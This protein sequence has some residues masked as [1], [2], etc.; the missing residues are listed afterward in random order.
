[1]ARAEKVPRAV[2]RR[3]RSLERDVPRSSALRGHVR[4]PSSRPSNRPMSR[5][6][7]PRPSRVFPGSDRASPSRTL[8]RLR[9]THEIY[10]H[11]PLS[12]TPL[13]DLIA[14]EFGG[15]R[16]AVEL[17][18]GFL[19][20]GGYD[21]EFAGRL[22]EVAGARECAPSSGAAAGRG[23]DARVAG[24]GAAGRGARR[25][26]RDPECDRGRSR[27]RPPGADR[28]RPSSPRGTARPIGSNT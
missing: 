13:L 11:L 7:G 24:A 27:Q 26:G 18:G 3:A 28:A 5:R 4:G 21:R 9:P 16:L 8:P 19:I 1:M 25:A 22:V 10:A 15:E 2:S 17:F 6:A 14:E 23:P 20:R 12:E